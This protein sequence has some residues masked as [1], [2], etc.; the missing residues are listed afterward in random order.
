M[1]KFENILKLRNSQE[2]IEFDRYC[3]TGFLEQIDFFRYEDMH[4]NFL[5]SL[6]K[7]DNV[8]G[9]GT[10]PLKLFIELLKVKD[11]NHLENKLKQDLLSNYSV[12][13]I[14]VLTQESIDVGRID[15]LIKFNIEN[16]K[17]NIIF[18]N[19]L[20]SEESSEGQTKRYKEYFDNHFSND[21]NI[22]VFLS[23]DNNLE[24]SA[25]NDYIRIDYQELISYVFEPCS[26]LEANSLASISVEEYLKG[27]TYL[28][29]FGYMPI[30]STLRKLSVAIY[31]NYCDIL[32]NILNADNEYIEFYNNNIKQFKILFTVLSKEDTTNSELLGKIN[33]KI[34]GNV[35]KFRD[36]DY[37]CRKQTKMVRV[38]LKDL[39]DNGYLK[40]IE[41]LDELK[42]SDNSSWKPT[43]TEEQYKAVGNKQSNY[44]KDDDL[45]LESKTLYYSYP[46]S[47]EELKGF[48]ECVIKKYPN[49]KTLI[50]VC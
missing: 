16:E 14:E 32:M 11:K 9:L 41:D 13:N 17:Y 36:I 40:T 43:I 5:A 2:W 21:N 49:Y 30:T 34:L 23:L 25:G 46:V 3:N 35:G 28:C 42:F 50:E 47:N 27:F 8:F 31:N 22:Y 24:I 1:D 29:E 37:S 18:E 6:L 4:T 45:I 12:S 15:L 39:I 20:F 48:V 33:R 7:E 38:I 10:K 26:Y 44:T 19:K